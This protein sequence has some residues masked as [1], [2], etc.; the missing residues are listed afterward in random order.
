MK[1]S[2]DLRARLR[3]I[4][5]RGYPAYKD[6]KGQYDFGD[7]V[8]SIDHVQ[9]DPFAAPSQLSI[10]MSGR[11]AGFPGQLYALPCQRV[12]L[13]DALTRHFGRQAARASFQ[14]TRSQSP[15][16]ISPRDRPRITVTED[17]L[18][19]LPPVSMSMGI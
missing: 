1:S 8:L 4:D 11:Q 9:G 12:A 19:Q 7:Y 13:Q 3:A 15:Q 6:L 2:E 16:A 5:H 17:W 18:P 14:A 10:H